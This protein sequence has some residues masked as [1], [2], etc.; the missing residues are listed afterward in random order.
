MRRFTQEQSLSIFFGVLFIAALVGQAIAGHADHN[1]ER[2]AHDGEPISLGRYF[3]SSAFGQA[4]R[5]LAVGVPAVHALQMSR[6]LERC[7]AILG[8][9]VP[10]L[11]LRTRRN[12]LRRPSRP[13]ARTRCPWDA[14]ERLTAPS[15]DP[16]CRATYR[17][18]G[19]LVRVGRA[20]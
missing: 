18:S 4:V 9:P 15:L 12:R 5:E 13:A 16:D 3:V 14:D 2:L 19:A 8:L 11:T 10:R 17:G 7:R 6:R 20:A 1:S